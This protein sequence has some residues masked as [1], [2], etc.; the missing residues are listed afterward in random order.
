MLAAGLA[1]IEKGLTPPAPIEE[2]VYEMTPEKRKRLKIGQLSEDLWE[3][4]MVAEKSSFLKECLG[5]HVF[6]NFIANKKIEWEKYRAQ[7][8]NYELEQYLSIL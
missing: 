7:V 1:G 8:T 6:E 5:E 2:N 4:I 3:A